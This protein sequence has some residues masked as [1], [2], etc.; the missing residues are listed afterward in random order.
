MAALRERYAGLVKL[1][2]EPMETTGATQTKWRRWAGF[3]LMLALVWHILIGT[4]VFA[5]APATPTPEP[6]PTELKTQ[7]VFLDGELLFEVP[8]AADLTAL[9][10]ANTVERSLAPLLTSPTLAHI[11]VE[12]RGDSTTAEESPYART[13]IIFADDR[14]IM[15]VTSNDVAVGGAETPQQQAQIWAKTIETTLA[16]VR[17]VRA[18]GLYWR[19]W[20]GTATALVVAFAISWLAGKLWHDWL[21]T[22]FS[23]ITVWSDSIDGDVTGLR[24]LFHITLFLVRLTVWLMAAAYIANQFPLTRRIRYLIFNSLQDGLFSRNLQLG[25]QRYSLFDLVLLGMVL[26]GVVIAA[27]AI[28]NLLRSRFLRMTGISMAAQEAIAI[29]SKY[30]MMLLGLVIVLQLWGIDLSSIALIAS[31]LGIGIGLGLQNI[32]KDF[33]SG[34]VMVFERPVQVG[35]FVDFG[36]LKG[37]ITRIGSRGTEI[38][39]LD[40]VSIIVPNSRFLENEISNWSHGNPVSRIRLPVGVSYSSDPQKVQEALLEACRHNQQILKAP[41]PLVLFTGF[42][43]SALEFE[44]AVWISQPSRQVLIRSDLYFA[45]EASLRRHSIEIPF[46]QRDLHI[47]S[48]S[49]PLEASQDVRHLLQNLTNLPDKSNGA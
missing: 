30:T 17:S 42:G 35:D 41:A 29:L 48:G 45:I 38:R 31:G 37:T 34:L 5:D 32:V 10:R 6:S 46:P 18:G 13:P 1:S 33:V 25:N 23:R 39:T 43:D 21:P 14:Y 28:T 19:A 49:L 20:V 26:L 24:F 40:H 44:L 36:D 8:G 2:Q 22:L 47:R 9:E 15:S 7:P 27:S 16:S 4:P 12:T 11:R 3:G